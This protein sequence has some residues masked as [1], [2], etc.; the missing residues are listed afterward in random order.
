MKYMVTYRTRA[1]G[2]PVGLR[3]S[4]RK[5]AEAYAKF[6]AQMGIYASITLV[7]SGVV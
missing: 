6:A 2:V 1:T 7:G 5:G 4:T 3:F